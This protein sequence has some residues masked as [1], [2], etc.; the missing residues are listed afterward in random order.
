MKILQC[1]LNFHKKISFFPQIEL[2]ET[3]PIL[4]LLKTQYVSATFSAE[5]KQ[6]QIPEKKSKHTL[7]AV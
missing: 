5:K 4:H 6:L 3:I 7:Q 1:L 2:E